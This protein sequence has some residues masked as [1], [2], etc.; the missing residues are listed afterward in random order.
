M[1]RHV[2]T[3][4]GL[5]VG[6]SLLMT[7]VGA[8]SARADNLQD[9]VTAGSQYA[10]SRGT[11]IALAVLDRATGQYRDNGAAAHQP[12]ESASVMK[13]FIAEN[14]LHRRDLGQI[15]LSQRDLNDMVRMLR[16]SYNPAANRFWS[17]YGANGIVRDVISRYGLAET[18]LTSH[19]GY[20]GNTLIT[21]HDMVRFYRRLLSGSGGLSTGS[22]DFIIEQL[23]RSTPR[24]ADGTRQFFGLHDGFLREPIIGQKQGWMCCPN[25]D[26]YRHSTGFI[27]SSARQIIVALSEEPSTQ[28]AAHIEKSLT[29]AIQHMFPEGRVPR[30]QDATPV[31][32][33]QADG[34]SAPARDVAR[35]AP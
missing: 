2:P 30:G 10:S 32:G 6:L 14:L 33:H 20:W 35:A 34:R 27:G 5:F 16:S 21:A 18:G 22:R 19:P 25:G 28:G 9:R 26:I 31:A 3:L 7:V 1:K 13:V 4:L 12:I 17:T 11:T 8:G 24:G 15:S 29:G 23:R